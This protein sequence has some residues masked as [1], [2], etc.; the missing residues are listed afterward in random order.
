MGPYVQEQ[1][2]EITKV[3]SLVKYGRKFTKYIQHY[4]NMPTSN[5]F[6]HQKMKTFSWKILVVFIFL[7]KI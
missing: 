1:K 5:I 2:Q 4:E 7:L 3:V 6:Y